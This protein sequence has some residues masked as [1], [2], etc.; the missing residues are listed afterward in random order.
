L[1]ALLG[2]TLLGATLLAACGGGS[3]A[4]TERTPSTLALVRIGVYDPAAG[5]PAVVG[6]AEITA[7]DAASRRLFVVNGALGSVDVLDLSAPASPRRVGALDLP[8]A[9]GAANSVAVHD[10]L[11]AVAV[12]AARKTDPGSVV[13][14]R[15]ADLARLATVGVGA[16]PDMLA[17]TPDGKRVVVANEGEPDSYGQPDS[18]DPEG[19]ISIIDVNR[20]GSSVAPSVR[21]AGFGAWDARIDELRSQGVRIYGPGGTVSRDLE[22]EYV[23]ISEDGNTAWVT[24]QENNAIATVDIARAQVTAIRALALKDH[25]LAGQGLDPSDEDGGTD[26]NS[27][28]AAVKIGNWPVFGMPLPDA[29]AS[30]TIDGQTYLVTA[31][32]G[33]ARADWPGFNEEVRV[34]AHC[35]AGLDPAV[36][37]ADAARLLFDSNLGRLRVTSTPNGN[38]T[39][40]NAAG[41]CTKLLAYGTRSFT[42][43]RASDLGRVWDSGD[44]LEQRTQ[45]LA[46]IAFNASHDNNTRDSRSPSKGPEP[47]GVVLGRFGAKTFAFVGL[48]RV[49]GVVVYDITVPSTP[50]FVTYFNARVG[51][52]GDLGP[53]GLLLIPA[54]Q[55]PNGKPLLVIGNE[56]SGTTAIV[57][58]NLI[59]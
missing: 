53:E 51:T 8:V 38:D 23:T 33:D 16:L 41:Q 29:I 32:E 39:G 28:T 24:L 47:E 6:A 49:G 15:A 43:W 36:F 48:E 44:Q 18:V 9:G 45:S 17:F 2:V 27:G 22:P 25:R 4:S 57:Q 30:Y 35:S 1:L 14:F 42:I 55:S 52:T 37:G 56:V 59:D 54:S 3:D 26:T 34:R 11:V 7:Y 12:Q 13:F 10:G 46:D 40:K 19:S 21:T 20:S 31:N 58:I 5:G 50:V